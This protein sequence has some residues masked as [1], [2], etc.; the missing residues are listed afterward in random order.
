MKIKKPH[1]I[2]TIIVA[3]ILVLMGSSVIAEQTLEDDLDPYTDLEVTITITQIRSL[4]KFEYPHPTIEFIDFMGEPDFYVKVY[5]NDVE[6]TSDIW[7]NTRYIYEP[8]S[9][10][11]D[12]PDD[13]ELVTIKIQLWD[14]NTN[15]DVLCDISSEIDTKDIEVVYSLK[16]GHWSGLDKILDADPSGYGRLNGCDDGTIHQHDRDCEL[17]FEITQ[18][19]YDGDGIPYWTE[20]NSYGTDPTVDNT[21][22]DAD[23]DDIPIEWEWK[24]DYDP[25]NTNNHEKLDPDKDGI[26]NYE[27]YR[28][29]AWGSDP[30]R[31]DIFV[32]LDYMETSP[33]GVESN[34]P[35]GAKELLKTAFARYNMVFHLD[36]GNMG[37][38]G[39]VI[40]F[41]ELLVGRDL[42][43]VYIDYFL[44]NDGDNWRRSVFRYGLVVYDAGYAGYNFIR[45]AYQISSNRVNRKVIPKTQ[46]FRDITY[47]SVYMH[48][49]GHTLSIWNEG[50]DDHL[51]KNPFQPNFWLWGPYKSC[52]NYR[53]TYRLVD[54]SDGSRGEND[55]NDWEDMDLTRFQY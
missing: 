17:F 25:F 1:Q 4:Q 54:Y 55:F 13:E 12:V 37:G 19:D 46:Y 34:L 43:N 22:E 49:L 26:D 2:P 45:G 8:W 38:G 47:A 32:E 31:Q 21:G 15:R 23:H 52:M 10:T 41:T 36:D 35:E 3:T 29:A 44:H 50:V 6:F 9:A 33:T 14:A 42:E 39:E 51:S 53:Y 20:V 7:Q 30:Y 28:M 18:S 27:E 5:I 40:P 11:L 24:W 48:E 16:T